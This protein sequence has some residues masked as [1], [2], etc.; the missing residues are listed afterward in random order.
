VSSAIPRSAEEA[1]SFANGA[2]A[3]W[4]D[5]L[6]LTDK[7]RPKTLLANAIIAFREALEWAGILAYDTFH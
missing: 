1:V 3:P 5:N 4:R 2:C 7:R 6:I